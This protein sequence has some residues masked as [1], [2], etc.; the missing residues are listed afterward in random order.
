[1]LKRLG[2]AGRFGFPVFVIL[3]QKGEVIHIQDSALL[4]EGDGY[5]RKKVLS[6]FNHWTPRAV[7]KETKIN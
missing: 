2:N 3:N 4:E 7:S 1:M 5:N 6:F